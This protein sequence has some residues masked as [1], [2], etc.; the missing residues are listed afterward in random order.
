MDYDKGKELLKDFNT[1]FK[2]QRAVS[3]IISFLE[4]VQIVLFLCVLFVHYWNFFEYIN[5]PLVPLFDNGIRSVLHN[6]THFIFIIAI[7]YFFPIKYF[8]EKLI[9]NLE[10]SR[11]VKLFPLWNTI[12]DLLGIAFAVIIA[13]FFINCLTEFNHGYRTFDIRKDKVFI[14]FFY[15]FLFKI[16]CWIYAKNKRYWE[17]VEKEYTPYFDCEGNRIPKEGNVVYNFKLYKVFWEK[18]DNDDLRRKGKW[19]LIED[20]LGPVY[21]DILLEDAVKD[22]SGKIKIYKD[23]MGEEI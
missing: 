14:I 3:K 15:L 12:E 4:L 2:D 8:L 22:E 21:L 7:L 11:N 16:F 9:I 5:L 20:T 10:V 23:R 1:I 13:L 17:C 18:G 6:Y 19:Y